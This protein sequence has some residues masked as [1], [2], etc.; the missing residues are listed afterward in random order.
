[1]IIIIILF[2]F[3]SLEFLKIYFPV[4]ITNLV[5]CVEMQQ[6]SQV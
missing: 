1:M 2:F 3:T 6:I 5:I 4:L